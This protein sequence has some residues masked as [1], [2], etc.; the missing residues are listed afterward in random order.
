MTAD[1]RAS[2]SIEASESVSASTITRTRG[3]VPDGRIRTRPRPAS[4]ASAAARITRSLSRLMRPV[5]VG[6]RVVEP[7]QSL[8]VELR[9]VRNDGTHTV[10]VSACIWS[11]NSA[12]DSKSSTSTARWR[13]RFSVERWAWLSCMSTAA[14]M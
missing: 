9:T 4:R 13:R 12:A 6:S 7:P 1:A 10:S 11:R 5:A 14:V 8:S 2:A 3:S